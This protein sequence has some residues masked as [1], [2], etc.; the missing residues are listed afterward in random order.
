MLS[1]SIMFIGIQLVTH[2][3]TITRR[4]THTDILND[5]SPLYIFYTIVSQFFSSNNLVPCPG[6]CEIGLRI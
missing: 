3:N 4:H 5:D 2:D 1:S 6:K